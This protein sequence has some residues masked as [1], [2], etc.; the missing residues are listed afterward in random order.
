VALR[1]YV[2]EAS[3]YSIK[4]WAMLRYAGFE[5]DIRPQNALNRYFVIKR[6][7]GQTIVPVLIDESET[8]VL[9]DSTKIARFILPNSKRPLLPDHPGERVLAWMLEDYADEWMVRW[10]ASS[11]WRHDTISCG[12]RIGKELFFQIPI[13][14]GKLGVLVGQSLSNRLSATGVTSDSPTLWA[15]RSRLLAEMDSILDDGDFLFGTS[16][17]VADFAVYGILWQHRSD[18][19][20]S[21]VIKSFKNVNSYVDRVDKWRT[22]EVDLPAYERRSLGQLESLMGEVLGTYMRMLVENLEAKETGVKEATAVFLDGSSLTFRTSSYLVARLTELVTLIVEA[23]R[24]GANLLPDDG[25]KIEEGITGFLE[26]LAERKA[27]K[28]LL[29]DLNFS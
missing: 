3:P 1:L 5:V 18:P 14:S 8:Q 19:S 9:N 28:R 29:R 13:V 10:F 4:S 22:Q 25:A 16:P 12:K 26:H 2:S 20:G 23:S 27:G 6:L 15:S 11:R 21:E 17:T 24:D 7:L